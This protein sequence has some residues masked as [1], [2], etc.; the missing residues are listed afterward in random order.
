MQYQQ[1]L[2]QQIEE[3]QNRKEKER[4]EDEER[5][6][7][8]LAEYQSTLPSRT[9]Q[10]SHEDRREGSNDAYGVPRA[11]DRR[12][13]RE[14]SSDD[15]ERDP[16]RGAGLVGHKS[17]RPVPPIKLSDNRR[18][19]SDDDGSDTE[20]REND[21]SARLYNQRMQAK[22]GSAHALQQEQRHITER[23]RRDNPEREPDYSQRL[24]GDS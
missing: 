18:V 15:E 6:R 22:G 9:G 12:S 10:G 21:N 20:Y 19:V 16:R 5:K 11:G 23:R 24:A 4:R 2:Q 13:H 7:R 8:E 17:M 1:L 3:K 14:D